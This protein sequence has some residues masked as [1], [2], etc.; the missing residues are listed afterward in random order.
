MPILDMGVQS[1]GH[2]PRGRDL[3]GHAAGYRLFLQ[4]PIWSRSLR[5]RSADGWRDLLEPVVGVRER[6]L[7][8]LFPR[9]RRLRLTGASTYHA[10]G[11]YAIR[12]T[13]QVLRKAS[14]ISSRDP[15]ARPPPCRD[16][17]L[18]G[19]KF[20]K[21]RVS[22]T[23]GTPATFPVSRFHRRPTCDP[24]SG[25]GDHRGT[26]EQNIVRTPSNGPACMPDPRRSTRPPASRPAYLGTA[27]AR[28]LAFRRRSST[29]LPHAFGRNWSV[30][31]VVSPRPAPMAEVAVPRSCSKPEPQDPCGYMPAQLRPAA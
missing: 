26:A 15:L 11:L 22:W 24:A 29:R 21:R 8:P 23:N 5:R 14:A 30:A 13:N 6:N 3:H 7:V 18:S 19:W 20:R 25:G 9:G 28:T 31:K 27:F 2:V 1:F 16:S 17:L 4:P 12:S 10:E